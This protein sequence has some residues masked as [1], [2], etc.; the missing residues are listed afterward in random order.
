MEKGESL[1]DK[2]NNEFKKGNFQEAI[3]LYTEGLLEE[4]NEVLYGNR[5]A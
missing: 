5:A 2:G 1:K 4:K 3:A